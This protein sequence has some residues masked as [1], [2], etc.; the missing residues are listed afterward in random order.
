MTAVFQGVLHRERPLRPPDAAER[1]KQAETIRGEIAPLDAKLRQFRPLAQQ[2]R[3]LLLDTSAPPPASPTQPIVTQIEQPKNGRPAVYSAG[4]EKGQADDPGDV[5]RLPNLG[6]GYRY[7]VVKKGMRE[8]FISWEPKLAGR[9]RI[10]L[11]WG[12]YTTH[13]TD[14]RYVLDRDGDLRTTEDQVEIA[15][16]DQSKFADG[17]PAIVDQ[18]RWSGLYN[19]GVYELTPESRVVLRSGE[20]AGPIVADAVLFEEVPADAPANLA[21]VAPARAPSGHASSKRGIVSAGRGEIRALHDHGHE[22][23]RAVHR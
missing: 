22:F 16:V 10:W 4:K 20:V 1:L 13:V 5:T 23:R 18:K 3:V 2:G 6:E 8:D 9:Y 14:A 7:W 15:R 21:T 12:A 19:A 17:T 11:S